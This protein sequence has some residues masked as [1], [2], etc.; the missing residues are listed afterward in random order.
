[1]LSFYLT[2]LT[3]ILLLFC[4]SKKNLHEL[5]LL[6]LFMVIQLIYNSYSS[7]LTTNKGVWELSENKWDKVLYTSYEFLLIPILILL[8]MNYSAFM[9]TEI[10]KGMFFITSAF[11][12]CLFELLLQKWKVITYSNWEIWYSFTFFLVFLFI[13]EYLNRIFKRMLLNEGIFSNETS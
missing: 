13:L 12:L 4:V 9:K 8:F 5:T 6:F 1:M 7:I 11:A 2:I 3:I 10:L